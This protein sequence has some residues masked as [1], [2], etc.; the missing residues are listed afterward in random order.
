MNRFFR[1]TPTTFIAI[2]LFACDQI[3]EP[4]P[5]QL[6]RVKAK[7]LSELL[8]DQILHSPATVISLNN[9]V[10]S[11][12]LTSKIQSINTDVGKIIS[13]GDELFALECV[14][15][16]NQKKQAKAKFE[17]SQ[18][19]V[20]LSQ[21]DYERA[22]KLHRKKTI[23][24]Q[25]LDRLRSEHLLN[26]ANRDNAQAVF[27]LAQYTIS[28]CS[29]LSPFTGVV[30]ER[31][32]SVGE[33]AQPST[34]LLR[35]VD[36]ENLELSAQLTADEVKSLA[37]S[38]EIAFVQ[39][40]LRFPLSIR[41]ITPAINNVQR[42]QEVRLLFTDEKPLPGSSGELQ[43]QHPLPV[44]AAEY[45]S[46]RDGKLGILFLNQSSPEARVDFH[47]LDNGQEGQLTPISFSEGF[48][49]STLII[50]DGR[51]GVITDDTVQL[52]TE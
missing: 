26:I 10:V 13:K 8:A 28:K 24:V 35:I 11:A 31:M 38:T 18:V 44:L 32:V 37:N 42:T 27:E 17:K 1:L 12:E 15:E 23:S 47:I 20:N 48:T 16:L 51:Y 4:S 21:L 46:L 2:L 33:L 39:H 29:I 41:V 45:L 52:V 7:P 40:N 19:R 43:W 3:P 9:T 34:P 49:A 5:Q 14:D 22:Q 30:I 25:E 50:T 36:T 6:T